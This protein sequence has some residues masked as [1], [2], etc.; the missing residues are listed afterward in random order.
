MKT[1]GRMDLN[2]Q[3]TQAG[4]LNQA[5]WGHNVIY[6]GQFLMVVGGH[7]DNASTEKCSIEDGSIS[8]VSQKPELYNWAH[9]P[10]LTLVA[11]DFCK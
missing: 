1:I 4:E 6:D 10:E 3:W 11:D 5:R 2:G 9:Y 8:C 7:L